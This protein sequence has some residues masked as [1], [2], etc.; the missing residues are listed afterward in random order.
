MDVSLPVIV[1]LSFG[2]TGMLLPSE[3][4][5]TRVENEIGKRVRMTAISATMALCIPL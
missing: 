4:G 3:I 1:T 2:L 5:R